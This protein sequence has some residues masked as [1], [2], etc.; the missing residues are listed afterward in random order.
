[1]DRVSVSVSQVSATA[2]SLTLPSGIQCGQ[3]TGDVDAYSAFLPF[4]FPCQPDARGRYVRLLQTAPTSMAVSEVDFFVT[5]EGMLA[6]SQ[7]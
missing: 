4:C 7:Q 5:S 2:G 3:P 6:C 1:M